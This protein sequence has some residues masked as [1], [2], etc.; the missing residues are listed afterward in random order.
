M[1][2]FKT[3]WRKKIATDPRANFV[4]NNADK[5]YKYNIAQY[6]TRWSNL[7]ENRDDILWYYGDSSDYYTHTKKP[8]HTHWQGYSKPWRFMNI[9][10]FDKNPRYHRIKRG[11]EDKDVPDNKRGIYER[12]I[13]SERYNRYMRRS[14]VE[15]HIVTID[16]DERARARLPPASFWRNTAPKDLYNVNNIHLRSN[17]FEAIKKQPIRIS[18]PLINFSS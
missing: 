12:F 17:P 6:E 15:P 7:D 10:E 8:R 5:M 18:T 4:L 14:E 13:G 11:D 1:D 2:Y 9:E 16:Q 3:N